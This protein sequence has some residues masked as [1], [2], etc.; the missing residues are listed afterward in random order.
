MLYFKNNVCGRKYILKLLLLT[1]NIIIVSAFLLFKDCKF[2]SLGNGEV[3]LEP[4][5]QIQRR[6][7]RKGTTEAHRALPQD[8]WDK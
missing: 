5:G 6:E 7:Q 3:G 2:L 8:E 4:Q 1:Q